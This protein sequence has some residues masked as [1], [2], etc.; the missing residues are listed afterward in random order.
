MIRQNITSSMLQK[1]PIAIIGIASL[2]PEAE[3]NQKYWENIINKIDCIQEV[4]NTHWSTEDYYDPDPKTPDKTY[5]KKGGFIPK[6]EFNPIEFGIPPNELEVI[7]VSQLLSLVIAK[8]A[9]EDAGYGEKRQFARERVGVVIGEAAMGGQAS[10]PL[11]ARLEHPVWRKVLKSSGLSEEETETIIEKILASYKAWQVNSFPGMLG[12]IIA[13]RIANRL[14]LGGTNCT[15]DA[16]CASSLAAFKMAVS[17]LLE[18]GDTDIM[19]TG[20]VDLDN[21]AFAYLCFSKTPALSLKQQ[22]R[23]FDIDSDGMMLG[24]GI[25]MM[26]LKRLKDAENDGDRI[27]AVIKGIGTSSDGK[28]KSIYAPSPQGQVKAIRRAYQNAGFAPKTVKLIEAH[29]TGTYVGDSAEFAA[30]DQ[31]FS[32]D[33]A[34][35]GSIALGS[36]KSQIGHTKGAAGAAGVIKAALALHHK[37]LPPTINVTK[38]N[39]RLN[40]DKSPF[41]LNTETRPWVSLPEV[42]RRAA[43]SSFGFGGTNYHVVLEEY[44]REHDRPYRLHKTGDTIVLFARTPAELLNKSRNLLETLK[45]DLKEQSYREIVAKSNTAKIPLSDARVGFVASSIEEA[46]E[47]LE[48][49]LKLLQNQSQ[50]IWEHPQGIYYRESGL[51]LEGKVVALFPGQGSQYLEMG[52]ELA[53]NF[54]ELRQI[55]GQMDGLLT[56]DGQIELSQAIFPVPV[57]TEEEK[58]AQKKNLNRTEYAQPAIGAFSVG[59]YQILQKAGFKAD[60]CAGHSFGELTALWTAGV[61]SL[62][63][64]LFLVKTRGQ[65]M[66]SSEDVGSMLA[67]S[68]DLSKIEEI[69]NQFD[70]VNIA[71]YNSNKQV[72][73]GGKLE[74]LKEIQQ[75]FND[76]GCSTAILPVSAAFH[77]SNLN[78]AIEPFAKAIASVNFNKPEIPVYSNLTSKA[79]P[80][81]PKA[82]KNILKQQIINPVKFKQQIENIYADGGYCFV[83]I[84]PRNI[85]TRL[86]KDILGDRPHLAISLN[87]SRNKDSD[88]QLREGVL[89]LRVAGLTLNNLDPYQEYPQIVNKK[90]NPKLVFSFNGIN[91]ISEKTKE[92]AIKALNNR[93]KIVNLSNPQETLSKPNYNPIKTIMK[94]TYKSEKNIDTQKLSTDIENNLT[95]FDRYQKAILNIHQQYLEQQKEYTKIFFDLMHQQNSLIAS[96][97]YAAAT[98]EHKSA[99]IENFERNMLRFHQHQSQTLQ[100]Y[101]KAIE[102]QIE[103]VKNFCKLTQ[104]QYS[105]LVSDLDLARNEIFANLVQSN[106]SE[107][108]FSKEN[109]NNKTSIFSEIIPKNKPEK[110]APIT[111]K[112]IAT[113]GH[114]KS[115]STPQLDAINSIDSNGNKGGATFSLI[116]VF[117]PI[118]KKKEQKVPIDKTNFGFSE[119]KS[120]KIATNEH[121]KKAAIAEIEPTPTSGA[122]T[123][124]GYEKIANT[125]LEVV[126]EKTGYPTE[127]LEMD[128]DLE[129]D[130]G[131]DSIKRVEILGTLQEMYPDVPPP[132]PEEIAK[133]RTLV[134]ITAVIAN[135]I[136]DRN[137]VFVA[138][139]ENYNPTKTVAAIEPKENYNASETVADTSEIAKTLLEVVSEKTGYPTEMLEMDM[140]L[141]ADLGIGKIKGFEIIKAMNEHFPNAS[142][143]DLINIAQL[144]TLGETIEYIDRKLAQ[145]KRSLLSS[146]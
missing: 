83:E 105:L 131:I 95:R 14:D 56:R 70:S 45:S 134:Q 102:Q 121:N 111:S 93:H 55:Y 98:E 39:P 127:M 139:K 68:G 26:V 11:R 18:G 33:K 65:V 90:T 81:Y 59:S 48:I 88:R 143:M 78:Y 120:E 110:E 51:N 80:A 69:V 12:N 35:Y 109:S 86:V 129:A 145:K 132:N 43:V 52:K 89:Q 47:K 7:D 87:G 136:N 40:I 60:F 126:S 53:L 42:P 21:T 24:E 2:F 130:L 79:Y 54:P 146:I 62:E 92:T 140:D 27:Y 135:L 123:V 61:L 46:I 96:D 74:Q 84:G 133:L 23:P 112:T 3:N 99:I 113:N 101:E 57:F 103:S 71:N 4:P 100:G 118:H 82:I 64:Y 144:R 128:M 115:A 97:N 117:D 49:F 85:L 19:L 77:T 94:S 137:Q 29:G 91:Y 22:I 138:E 30:I 50:Q 13:G 107:K 15:L 67:I 114:N 44:S 142:K 66:G 124:V 1:N 122:N 25:G 72:V 17:E 73:L 41:Y 10:I 8:Q 31:V 119:D 108:V 28:Y 116:N 5:C 32:A 76:R 6:V 38:P 106:G 37:I 104:Q 34:S 58:A 63:D 16:A 9:M 141:E 36:V 75:I 125:L 20:G